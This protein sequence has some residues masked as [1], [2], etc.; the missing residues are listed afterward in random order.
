MITRGDI[1]DAA[2]TQL[3]AAQIAGCEA[4]VHSVRE[5]FLENGTEA[6]L[7]VDASYAFNS[8][9]RMSALHNVRHLCPS[10]ATILINTYRAHSELF[11][12]GDAIFSQEGTT[13]TQ[14]DPLAMPFPPCHLFQS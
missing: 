12:D 14:G 3:C 2:F 13:N 4:A 1:Q 7:L 11:I 8:L 5:R 6:A 10:I 9:N